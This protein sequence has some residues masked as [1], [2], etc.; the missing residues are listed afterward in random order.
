MTQIT[1][2]FANLIEARFGPNPEKLPELPDTDEPDEE[3][4]ELESDDVFGALISDCHGV[5]VHKTD[6]PWMGKLNVNPDDCPHRMVSYQEL[7]EDF[8]DT[9]L[10]RPE[11]ELTPLEAGPW[12]DEAIDHYGDDI[13]IGFQIPVEDEEYYSETRDIFRDTHIEEQRLM[14]GGLGDKV[15][16]VLR[17]TI[18]SEEKERRQE[19]FE[20]IL[21]WASTVDFKK[22]QSQKGRL[23]YKVNRSRKACG[24]NGLWAYVYLTKKQMNAINEVIKFRMEEYQDSFRR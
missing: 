22:L 13:E 12:E 8:W 24:K 21:A 2:H 11:E 4:L 16:N 20:K 6:R 18:L 1:S 23:W 15:T 9:P 5:R 19:R 7:C 10:D 17:M 3:Y 14:E